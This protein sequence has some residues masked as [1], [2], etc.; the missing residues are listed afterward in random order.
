MAFPSPVWDQLKGISKSRFIKALKRDG[1]KEDSKHGAITIYRHKDQRRVS[2]HYHPQSTF[3][4]KLLQELLVDTEWG[5]DDLKR[6][7]LIKK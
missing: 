3:G 7:K 6:L 5:E 4:P 2:I 1:F